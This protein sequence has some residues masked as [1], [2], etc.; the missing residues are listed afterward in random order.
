VFSRD[1][2]LKMKK[3]GGRILFFES[4]SALL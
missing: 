3:S 4:V 2:A 1:M